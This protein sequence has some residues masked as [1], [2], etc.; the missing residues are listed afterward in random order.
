MAQVSELTAIQNFYQRW[1]PR[2]YG[3]CCLLIGDETS[4][5]AVTAG[6]F[7]AYTGRGLEL[8]LAKLPEE[9]LALAWDL[10]KQS[11]TRATKLNV[12]SEKLNEA[13]LL[14]PLEERAVFILRSVMVIDELDAGSILGL[15]V[16]ALRRT[17]F[18]AM[19]EL[20]K[21]LPAN[22]FKERSA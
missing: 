18:R 6:A 15:P 3:F 13:I 2:V 16:A 14:L 21:L 5:E 4:A 17:W 19:L 11:T 22:P 12:N 8:D 7:R 20:R 1:S 9:L 10:S